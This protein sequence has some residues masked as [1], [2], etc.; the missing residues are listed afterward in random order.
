MFEC[1]PGHLTQGYGFLGNNKN[2]EYTGLPAPTILKNDPWFG[3][4]P[5]SDKQKH[6]EE[7]AKVKNKLKEYQRKQKTKES[8]NIHQIIYNIATSNWKTK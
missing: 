7:K 1:G 2:T 3:E 4:A 5:K 8:E 6:Y